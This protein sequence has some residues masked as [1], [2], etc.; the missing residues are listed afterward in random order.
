MGI[1]KALFIEYIQHMTPEEIK[2]NLEDL[3]E[4]EYNRGYDDALDGI[5]DE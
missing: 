1:N 3:L 4:E 2:Q 5:E